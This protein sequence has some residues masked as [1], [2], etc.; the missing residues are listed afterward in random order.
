MAIPTLFATLNAAT[1][2][3]L[4]ANFAALGALTPIPS[5]G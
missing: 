5:V 2:A 4:D 1:G 3:E